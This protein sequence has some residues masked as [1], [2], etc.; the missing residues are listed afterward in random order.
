M[1]NKIMPTV[2]QFPNARQAWQR[3]YHVMNIRL[4][5]AGGVKEFVHNLSNQV[6]FLHPKK[7]IVLS[8]TLTGSR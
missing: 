3:I 2:N 4:T 7:V 6:I 8:A 5:S 1:D